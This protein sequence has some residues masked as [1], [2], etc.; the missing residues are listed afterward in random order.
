[1]ALFLS[2][3]ASF[4]ICSGLLDHADGEHLG[5]RGLLDFFVQLAGELVKALNSFAEFLSRFVATM[6]VL[7]QPWL[8]G[9][10]ESLPGSESPRVLEV[11]G[12]LADTA[13]AAIRPLPILSRPRRAIAMTN[14]RLVSPHTGLLIVADRPS[15][16]PGAGMGEIW[17]LA[18]ILKRP[19]LTADR[20]GATWA[21]KRT[22][23]RPAS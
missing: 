14:P 20:N 12:E 10:T 11:A 23:R 2:I 13:R 1:L 15:M 4:F 3:L 22:H 7:R 21:R 18:L 6:L 16:P 9:L 8:A 17:Q 19:R 5:G